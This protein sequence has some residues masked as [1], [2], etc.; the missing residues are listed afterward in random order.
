MPLRHLDPPQS[1]WETRRFYFAC[2]TDAIPEHVEGEK[3]CSES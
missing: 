2:G 1:I 3:Q